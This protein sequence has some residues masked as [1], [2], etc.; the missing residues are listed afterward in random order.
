MKV[1]LLKDVKGTG[2]KGELKEVSDGFA[3]NFLIKN[4]YAKEATDAN[5]NIYKQEQSSL[6]FNAKQEEEKAFALAKSLKGKGI[7]IKAK[8]GEG[9]LF[10]SITSK[11]IA[12]KLKEEHS[13]VIDKRKILLKEPIRELGITT[14]NIKLHPKVT[15]TVR[16]N[17]V[18]ED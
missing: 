10:G 14:V 7:T 6:A 16:I 4:N 3:R 1:I 18:Q 8:A 17:V 9:K 2:K 13:I 15:A 5:I 12:D 11:D